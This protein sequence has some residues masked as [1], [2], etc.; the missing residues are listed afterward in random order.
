MSPAGLRAAGRPGSLVPGTLPS[1][2]PSRGMCRP[3]ERMERSPLRCWVWVSPCGGGA[4]VGDFVVSPCPRDT[5]Q[6]LSHSLGCLLYCNGH[7]NTVM[8]QARGRA[9]NLLGLQTHCW[10]GPAEEAKGRITGPSG[11]ASAVTQLSSGLRR[12]VGP[13]DLPP[14]CRSKAP[15]SGVRPR[16]RSHSSGA[17]P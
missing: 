1:S 13:W 14:V 8:A 12:F 6:H 16:R 3:T 15:W 2:M 4:C 7:Q 9:W 11:E 10:R 17:L 5:P